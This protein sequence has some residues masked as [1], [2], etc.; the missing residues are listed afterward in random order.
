MEFVAGFDQSG[1]GIVETAAVAAALITG[2]LIAGLALYEV[3]E[4]KRASS[5]P[6]PADRT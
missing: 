6:T 5:L 1:I 4:V 3:W 2:L